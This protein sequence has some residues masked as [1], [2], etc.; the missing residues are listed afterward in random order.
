[1]LGIG[2]ACSTYV[3]GRLDT[4]AGSL[5]ACA[6]NNAMTI[7]TLLLSRRAIRPMACTRPLADVRL[8]STAGSSDRGKMTDARL[9]VTGPKY[10]TVAIRIIYGKESTTYTRVSLN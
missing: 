8:V 1:M 10:A 9:D 2:K 7:V 4:K 6:N 5:L 3:L